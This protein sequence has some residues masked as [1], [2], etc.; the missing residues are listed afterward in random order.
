MI[1]NLSKKVVIWRL[2]G[3][4]SFVTILNTLTV[5]KKV[6]LLSMDIVTVTTSWATKPYGIYS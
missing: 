1:K 4:H 6:L 3:T 2:E 5:G